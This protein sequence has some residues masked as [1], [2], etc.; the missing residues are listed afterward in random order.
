M[1]P[2]ARTETPG[3]AERQ[4]ADS[5][6][7]A[8]EGGLV[9]R[10]AQV[11]RQ[12]V[13]S[14]L[15]PTDQGHEEAS[16][17][18]AG[19]AAAGVQGE[20]LDQEQAVGVVA[21]IAE[22]AKTAVEAG[23]T[24][25]S[26]Q[27]G[28][29][30]LGPE[31]RTLAEVAAEVAAEAAQPDLGPL[32]TQAVDSTVS[33]KQTAPFAMSAETM[34]AEGQS[35]QAEK[36]QEEATDLAEV[37][38]LAAEARQV[39]ESGY[40][41]DRGDQD[42]A[43]AAASM[44]VADMS[45]EE[46]QPSIAIPSFAAAAAVRAD[47]V[48]D[49][50]AADDQNAD[51]ASAELAAT[52]A[53]AGGVWSA[54]RPPAVVAAPDEAAAGNEP[55]MSQDGIAAQA[56]PPVASQV[57]PSAGEHLPDE[58]EHD[59][60]Q[61]VA[62]AAADTVLPEFAVEEFSMLPDEAAADVQ[63]A[64][65]PPAAPNPAVTDAAADASAAEAEGMAVLTVGAAVDEQP[66]ADPASSDEA[67]Q[68]QG[69]EAGQEV[70]LEQF[71]GTAAEARP[72]AHTDLDQAETE[73]AVDAP[74]AAAQSEENEAE[75]VMMALRSNPANSPEEALIAAAAAAVEDNEVRNEGSGQVDADGGLGL[76]ENAAAAAADEFVD[77]NVAD[78]AHEQAQEA[79]ANGEEAAGKQALAHLS[80]YEKRT[81]WVY[82]FLR[83]ATGWQSFHNSSGHS[84]LSF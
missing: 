19:T 12:I 82:R 30:R 76:D 83:P 64:A 77:G 33:G 39:I 43:P 40:E 48:D 1:Q 60:A 55:F 69:Q 70:P 62:A 56:Q 80:I 8:N 20:R 4:G 66:A 36:I 25:D 58:E 81:R 21:A 15:H 31:Y 52:E 44:D 27:A 5:A 54:A 32:E 61:K 53:A 10:V 84:L 17:A 6:A 41:S 65:E 57:A 67:A 63:T 35:D 42:E 13:R 49:P 24:R 28:G 23:V 26:R 29:H 51:H 72:D 78:E 71:H 46:V 9:G 3:D 22:V 16:A 34:P 73:A 50:G 7:H 47:E 18:S 59:L 14:L 38:A 79:G 74:A 11:S 68:D 2:A 75:P 37:P 45:T